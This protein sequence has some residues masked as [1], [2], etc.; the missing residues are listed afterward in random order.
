MIQSTFGWIVVVQE[1]SKTYHLRWTLNLSN[2]K[3]PNNTATETQAG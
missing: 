3:T 1:Q 2:V